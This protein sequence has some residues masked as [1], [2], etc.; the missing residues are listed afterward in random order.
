MQAVDAEAKQAPDYNLKA[1]EEKGPV[2]GNEEIN[3]FFFQEMQ[4]HHPCG[5]NNPL[6]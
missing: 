2:S 3:T 4:E 6:H 5:H 1:E